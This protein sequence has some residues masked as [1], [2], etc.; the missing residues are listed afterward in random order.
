MVKKSHCLWWKE[1]FRHGEKVLRHRT[2]SIVSNSSNSKMQ[3]ILAGSHF[4][5]VVD[6]QVL[7]WLMSLRDPTGRLARSALT[8]QGYD[9]TIQYRPGKDHGN[10]DA[11]SQRVHTISQQLIVTKT[12]TEELCNAQNRDDKLQPLIRYLQ[13]GTLPKDTATAEK[14]L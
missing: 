5:V 13:V 9:F 11:L 14:I 12:S 7:K 3:T 10:V 2:R 4:T 1:L 8:L 6:H